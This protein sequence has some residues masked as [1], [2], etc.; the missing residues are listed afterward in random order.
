[1]LSVYALP[2]AEP[3][4]NLTVEEAPEFFA[5]GVLVHNCDAMRYVAATIERGMSRDPG[6]YRWSTGSP[7]R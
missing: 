3:V 2:G 1:M 5:N 7:G 6:E 4:F